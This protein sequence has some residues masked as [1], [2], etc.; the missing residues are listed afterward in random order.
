[1]FP[2]LRREMRN[3]IWGGFVRTRLHE[4]PETRLCVRTIGGNVDDILQLIMVEEKSTSGGF[5]EGDTRESDHSC[6]R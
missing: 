1:V 4:A 5:F 3:R 6:R 2:P